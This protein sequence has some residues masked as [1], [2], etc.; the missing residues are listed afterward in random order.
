MRSVNMD[1]DDVCNAMGV[2][3]SFKELDGQTVE[4]T[5]MMITE[6]DGD[7]ITTMKDADGET[8]YSGT[9][10]P[11]RKTASAIL[12]MVTDK[13]A[14]GDMKEEDFRY[15]V[16]FTEGGSGK[17]TYMLAKFKRIK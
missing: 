11:I 1:I 16:T 10:T 4:I 12:D 6:V 14:D 15:N 7:T 13:I 2:S 3:T 8:Y 5:G 17:R 9:S